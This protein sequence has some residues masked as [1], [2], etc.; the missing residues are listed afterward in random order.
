MPSGDRT[1]PWGYGS[2]TGRGLG[3]CSGTKHPG[4]IAAGP[5]FGF[6]RGRGR[7]FG[8]GAGFGRG[9]LRLGGGPF[10]GH[11]YPP[12]VP[13]AYQSEVADVP[14]VD[15]G[16]YLAEEARALEEELALINKRRDELKKSKP[17]SK[18]RKGN[19][20]AG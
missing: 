20:A 9:F 4:F 19:E 6:G 18:D 11:F 13:Y 10:P 15:E 8:R 12:A 3:Y 7:G 2:R 14:P 1:G 5:G 17:K 16:A